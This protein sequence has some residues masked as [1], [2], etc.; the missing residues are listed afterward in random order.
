M[1]QREKIQKIINQIGID[2]TDGNKEADDLNYYTD[3][4]FTLLKPAGL[5]IKCDNCE[6]PIIEE[7]ALFFTPPDKH[8]KTI[9]VHICKECWTKNYSKTLTVL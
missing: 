6:Q 7:G 9:K 5:N 8:R 3:Q 1:E 2:I 4:L